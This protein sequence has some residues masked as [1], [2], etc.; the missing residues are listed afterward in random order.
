MTETRIAND[1]LSVTV[2]DLGA[3]MQS[4]R[5]AQGRDYLWNGDPAFWSG[6]SPI[7]FPIVGRAPGDRITVAGHDA[8]M[9]QHGFARRSRFALVSA[10]PTACTHVLTPGDAIRAVYPPAFRLELTHRLDGATLRVTATVTNPGI[11]PLPFGL[12]FHPAFRWPLPGAEGQPHHVTLD[13]GANPEMARLTGGLL[14][15]ERH[16][17]PFAEGRLTLE[18]SL[19]EADAMLFPGS[20]IPGL[21]YGPDTGPRLRFGFDNLPDLALWTKPGAPFVCIEPWHGTAARTTD[22]PAIEDRPGTIL[23]PPGDSLSFRW[24]VTPFG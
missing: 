13:G 6:R 22:G 9:A 3:E 12:G 21:T 14:P 1:H 19:F 23:L 18:Q 17:S 2:S 11:A 8:P 10:D 4:L 5:D 20:A 16:P 24:S 15:P 7:L